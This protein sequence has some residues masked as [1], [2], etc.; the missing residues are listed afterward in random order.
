[1]KINV[2]G[3]YTITHEGSNTYQIHSHGSIKVLTIWSGATADAIATATIS[4][5]EDDLKGIFLVL[6]EYFNNSAT[7]PTADIT[8]S[9]T[10]ILNFIG[11]AVEAGLQ[12]GITANELQDVRKALKLS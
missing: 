3:A 11:K 7:L 9:V 4:M 8:T 2:N 12:T 5:T 6:N 1:M 10:K